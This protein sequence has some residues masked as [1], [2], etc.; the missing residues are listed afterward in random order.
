[1]EQDRYISTK[2]I[3]AIGVCNALI[4]SVLSVYRGG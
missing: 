4:D 2:G 3:A 1:M